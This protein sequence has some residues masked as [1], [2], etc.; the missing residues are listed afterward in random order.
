MWTTFNASDTHPKP[1]SHSAH[2]SAMQQP[3]AGQAPRMA[4]TVMSGL[5]CSRPRNVVCVIQKSAWRA[6]LVLGACSSC[7]QAG[8]ASDAAV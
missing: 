3:P 2:Q 4:A 6:L 1:G 5:R 8:G 7:G